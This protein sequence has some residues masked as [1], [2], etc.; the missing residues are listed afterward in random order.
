MISNKIREKEFL[1]E[2]VY[3]WVD[4]YKNI[5][6]Q[7]FNFSPRFRCEYDEDTKELNII[8]KDETGEF[9]PKNFFG[10]NINVTAI[11]GENG[12]GKSSILTEILKCIENRKNIFLFHD[13]NLNQIFLN[14]K[15]SEKSKLSSTLTKNNINTKDSFFYH[16]KNDVNA[17]ILEN[18]Y[19]RY[20]EEGFIFTEPNKSNNVLDIKEEETETLKK[21]IDLVHD[22]VY[23][24][25]DINKFFV[26]RVIVLEKDEKILK[27]SLTKIED[28]YLKK[29][30]NMKKFLDRKELLLLE[31]ILYFHSIFKTDIGY[32]ELK[33]NGELKFNCD[34][35]S[36]NKKEVEEEILRFHS[37]IILQSY[38][39]QISLHLKKNKNLHLNVF[40]LNELKRIFNLF[41]KIDEVLELLEKNADGTYSSSIRIDKIYQNDNNRELLQNLPKFLKV[42]FTLLK[43]FRYSNLSSGERIFLEILYSVRNIIN[44]REKNESCKNIFILIDE[45]ENSLHPEW[46]KKLIIGLFSFLKIYQINIHIIIATHSPFILS[47]LPKENIIFLEKGKQVYPFEDGKQTFG[48]NI[49]TLL[50][51]GFFMKDGLMGEFAKSKIDDVI[52]YLNNDKRSTITTDEDAQNIIN[53]IGEP[54]IKREL[55]R[56]LKNKMELSNKTEIDKIREKVDKLTKELEESSKRLVEL[57]KKEDK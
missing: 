2:L 15:L 1:M 50:S 13:K 40:E 37:Q 21:L 39:E 26:P 24:K 55:Q 57:E 56:M 30:E 16:Y 44:L 43:R 7:G 3:L 45:V 46:Q 8:D 20:N 22:N 52:K 27:E 17:P 12:S 36:K 35:L 34:V 6:N 18:R 47:D 19:A 10:D 4:K 51:H 53:I 25:I 49:H 54:I 31:N 28:K 5:Q 23:E 42:E 9:Y 29:Y 48:A 33:N 38:E 14:T 41:K 11:V 32:F